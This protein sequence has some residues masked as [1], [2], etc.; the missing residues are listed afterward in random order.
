MIVTPSRDVVVYRNL[1]SKIL[2]Y[3]YG[4]LRLPVLLVCLLFL[5]GWR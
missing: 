1:E 3:E 2:T 4:F 5:I